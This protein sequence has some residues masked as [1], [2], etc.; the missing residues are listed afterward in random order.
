MRPIRL[1][2]RSSHQD[3]CIVHS[4]IVIRSNNKYEL[5]NSVR[6]IGVCIE[7]YSDTP[8]S[9]LLAAS[10]GLPTEPI[11]KPLT[12]KGFFQRYLRI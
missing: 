5:Y 11:H 9:N 12:D 3:I 8:M 4:A 2:A 1:T 7:I 6:D 10:H